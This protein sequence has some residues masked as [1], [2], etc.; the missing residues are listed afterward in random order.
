MLFFQKRPSIQVGKNMTEVNIPA[1]KKMQ[2]VFSAEANL[3]TKKTNGY[4]LFICNFVIKNGQ[5]LQK[6]HGLALQ[7]I[8]QDFYTIQNKGFTGE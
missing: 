6:L 5:K 3:K 4:P 7:V 2:L 1:K 8:Y